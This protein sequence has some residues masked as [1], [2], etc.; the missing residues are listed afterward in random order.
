MSSH[1]PFAAP[2]VPS[3]DSKSNKDTNPAKNTSKGASKPST[4][5]SKASPVPPTDE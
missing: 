1:D 5:S 3:K 4:V 2:E